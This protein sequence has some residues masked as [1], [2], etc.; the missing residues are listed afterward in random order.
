MVSHTYGKIKYTSTESKTMT[1]M[2]N[3]INNQDSVKRS[4]LMVTFSLK[5]VIKKFGQKGYEATYG[6]MLH[7]HQ[8]KY[9]KTN[10]SSIFES[11]R[12]KRAF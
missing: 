3:E 1:I 4:S 6:E 5:Q 2:I 12:E 7:I 8:I 10:R 9:Y 11:K